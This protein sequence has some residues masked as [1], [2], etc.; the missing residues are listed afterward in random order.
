MTGLDDIDLRAARHVI[1]EYARRRRLAGQPIP[2]SVVRLHTHVL[3]SACGPEHV[4]AQ[5]ESTTVEHVDSHQAADLLG[6]SERHV[7]RLAADLDGHRIAGR[8]VFDRSAVTDYA[9]A[10]EMSN[11]NPHRS[12]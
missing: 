2:S 9:Y 11:G 7:R 3:M 6:C 4:G 12:P 5:E 10:K 8:W 1:A